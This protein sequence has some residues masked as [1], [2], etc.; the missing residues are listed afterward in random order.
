MFEHS[1]N[2]FYNRYYD[3]SRNMS[4]MIGSYAIAVTVM[5]IMS[6]VMFDFYAFNNVSDENVIY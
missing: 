5:I 6:Q 4:R 3:P 2:K 1:E